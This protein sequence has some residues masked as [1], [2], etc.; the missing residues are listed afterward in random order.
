M[1]GKYDGWYEWKNDGWNIDMVDRKWCGEKRSNQ[2]S[3]MPSHYY[4][5]VGLIYVE[6]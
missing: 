6:G 5:V 3:I 1:N 4:V 2:P